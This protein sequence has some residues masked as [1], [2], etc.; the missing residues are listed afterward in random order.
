MAD[1][2]D[3][4]R[5]AHPPNTDTPLKSS[6]HS[7]VMYGEE[8]KQAQESVKRD[9]KNNVRIVSPTDF[10]RHFLGY[11]ASDSVSGPL[12]QVQTEFYSSGR[13]TKFPKK[14]PSR[15]LLEYKFYGPFVEI[16]EAVN[17]VCQQYAPVDAIE[18]VWLDRNAK[19]PEA[20]SKD[21]PKV[22]PDIV[23]VSKSASKEF[24]KLSGNL[25]VEVKDEIEVCSSR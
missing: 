23:Q 18:S 4:P 13:W 15:N 7:R 17:K 2:V 19:A 6:V 21:N 20:R 25:S 12:Q 22:R 5:S 14:E 8:A 10:Y 24:E 3:P 9:L 16:A 11:S 1:P